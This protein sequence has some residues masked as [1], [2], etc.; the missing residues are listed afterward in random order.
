[1]AVDEDTAHQ[2]GQDIAEWTPNRAC[3]L[4]TPHVVKAACSRHTDPTSCKADTLAECAWLQESEKTGMCVGTTAYYCSPTMSL[5]DPGVCNYRGPLRPPGA[6]VWGTGGESGDCD[7]TQS[8]HASYHILL[9]TIPSSC[10]M[11]SSTASS[12]TTVAGCQAACDTTTNCSGFSLTYGTE[13]ATPAC[14]LYQEC[15]NLQ[16]TQQAGTVNYLKVPGA[17]RTTRATMNTRTW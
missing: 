13:D 14:Q 9:D 5:K 12:A 11:N 16:T 4:D 6:G 17:C 15:D 7:I 3:T 10:E 1:M 8:L 2:W